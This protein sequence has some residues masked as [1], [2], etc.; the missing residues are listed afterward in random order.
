MGSGEKGVVVDKG[1]P[2][3]IF[4][5]LFLNS[6]FPQFLGAWNRHFCCPSSRTFIHRMAPKCFNVSNISFRITIKSKLS[7][8]KYLLANSYN[9]HIN[10]R[11]ASCHEPRKCK[12]LNLNKEN[13]QVQHYTDRASSHIFRKKEI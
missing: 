9:V 10:R 2:L 4:C 7:C 12:K 13:C 11:S 8:Y 5:P 6:R 3:R 1:K